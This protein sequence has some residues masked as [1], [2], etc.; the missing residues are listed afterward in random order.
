MRRYE[1]GTDVRAGFGYMNHSY[2]ILL[3]TGCNADVYT[4]E[5]IALPTIEKVEVVFSKPDPPSYGIWRRWGTRVT[6][7]GAF[8][9]CKPDREGYCD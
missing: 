8:V 7:G 1:H 5:N 2:L 6:Q 9:P 4:V 3:L